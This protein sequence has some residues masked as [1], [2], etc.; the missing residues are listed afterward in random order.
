MSK[1]TVFM[2]SVTTMILA[3][4]NQEQPNTS[5]VAPTDPEKSVPSAQDW[6]SFDQK[7]GQLPSEAG[8]MQVPELQK[9]ISAL[10]KEDYE[11]FK[12]DWNTET[13]LEMEDRILFTT[14][15]QHSDCK[16]NRYLLFFDLTDNNINIINFSFGRVR[17]WEEKAVIGLPSGYLKRFEEIREEQGL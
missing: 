11:R 13:P 17:T 4:K 6:S 16:A 12:K 9:R 5:S 15:C 3:C 1:I 8:F 2:L 14:G 10:L 7:V